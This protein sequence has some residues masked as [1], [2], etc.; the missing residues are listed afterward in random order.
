MKISKTSLIYEKNPLVGFFVGERSHYPF[1][2]SNQT[3]AWKVHEEVEFHS[4]ENGFFL[5]KFYSFEESQKILGEGSWFINEHPLATRRWTE[6]LVLEKVNLNAVP[7]W[8]NFPNLNLSWRSQR[9]LSKIASYIGNPIC[10]N[11][12]TA[13]N[14]CMAFA[15]VLM[16]IFVDSVETL[17]WYRSNVL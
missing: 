4:M 8:V 9:A 16:K 6:D 13:M 1:V 15:Q 10:M 7:L 2:K 14:K 12:N 3:K 11:E 5:V 17:E